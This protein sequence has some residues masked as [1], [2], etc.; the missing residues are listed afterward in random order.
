MRTVSDLIS[1]EGRV[2]LIT[3]G[4]GHIGAAI[5]TAYAELKAKVVVLDRDG[6]AARNVADRVKGVALTVDL[7]DDDAVRAIP[8]SVV[9]AC[10]RL[11][12]VVNNAA[13]VGTDAL[14]GWT[15][16]I[17]QQSL[18]TWRKALDVNLTAPFALIQAAIPALR[19]SGRASIINVGSIYGLVGPDWR[20][21]E[22]Q[23]FG[24]PAAYAA[25]KGG[26]L[27][28]TRWLATTLAPTIRVNAIVPGGVERKT[29][30]TFKQR[31]VAKVPL[32]RMATEEDMIGAAAYLAS[33]LSAYVTGQCLAVDGGWTAW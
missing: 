16:P 27:Q 13:F 17:E 14:Q 3:G 4:G 10:G 22:N 11:D 7:A 30:P 29:P 24:T 20:L 6:A 21:Y 2:A 9:A 32:A 28:M 25:S 18:D 12:I 23:S 26:L 8:D 19:A 5:A 33:D 15:T 31:Y 1:L